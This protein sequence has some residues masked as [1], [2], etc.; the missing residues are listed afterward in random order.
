VASF[1]IAATLDHNLFL[2]DPYRAN[3][4]PTEREM[5]ESAHW[6]ERIMLAGWMLAL[7]AVVAT[8]VWFAFPTSIAPTIC[9]CVAALVAA[10]T[11]LVRG[12][13]PSPKARAT[14]RLRVETQ[15]R[16]LIEELGEAEDSG[17][18]HL[19][20]RRTKPARGE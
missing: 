5:R 7:G 6:R 9:A 10:I 3:E 8:V 2:G 18:D 19:E 17:A 12:A 4:L 1:A 13:R 11:P 16:V 14:E 15:A 20:H